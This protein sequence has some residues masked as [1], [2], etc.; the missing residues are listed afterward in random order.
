MT[1]KERS[2]I[3]SVKT[4]VIAKIAQLNAVDFDKIMLSKILY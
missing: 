2:I 3:F 4:S 1:S